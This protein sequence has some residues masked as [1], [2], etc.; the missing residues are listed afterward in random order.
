[1][2]I[3]SSCGCSPS[4]S[5]IFFSVLLCPL[6]FPSRGRLAAASLLEGGDCLP[7][8]KTFL[9]HHCACFPS[10]TP[11]EDNEKI[12]TE[13]NIQSTLAISVCLQTSVWCGQ[14]ALCGFLLISCVNLILC[15]FS[16][17]ENDRIY[18]L[19]IITNDLIRASWK[20]FT[21]ALINN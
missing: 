1:M 16:Q 10:S 13:V 14:I 17:P 11:I 6:L 4:G 12:H 15:P 9:I 7:C 19:T 20:F 5:F 21:R 18:G 2:L 8:M 3:F